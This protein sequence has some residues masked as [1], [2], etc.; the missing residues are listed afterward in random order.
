MYK[1]DPIDQQI[2]NERVAQYRDQTR[3][4]LAGEL[5]DEEFRPLRLQN[6]LYIQR[7]APMLRIAVPYGLM[8]SKQLRKLADIAKRYDRGY[9]HFSTR[10]NLQ[11]NWPKLEDTPEILAEL[12]TV[13]MHAIQTSGNC[14]RNITTDQFA[15]IAPDEIIDPR[16]I[17]EIMRQWSTF[18]PE[19]ALLPR[20]FK[21]AVSGTEKD[22]AIV[23]AHDIGLE[24]YKDEQGQM[25]IKV[26]VGGGLGRTPILG[27][28][29][30][31]HLEWQHVL[32]YCEAVIR[33]YNIH[34]RRDNIYKAR[35]K[36][37][38]K[39]LG[40]DEFRRQVD[41]E[42]AHLKDGP[43]TITQAELDRVAQ[44]F[45]PMPYKTLPAHDASFDAAVASNPA[46]AAWIKRC[47]HAHRVPGYRAVTLSLKPHGKAP[48]DIT[49]DQMHV[50][51]DLA[52]AY[53]FGE[54][55]SSHEQN[56]ILA[57]VQLSD[58]F[59][60]WEKARA[61]GLATPN[62]GLLTDIICCPGGDFCSLANAK[63]IPI[64]EAIQMQF[65]NLDYLYEIGDLE[66][67]ISGCMNACGHHHVGHIG[68]L[69]VDK[70]GSE[71]YQVT[72]GGKQGN[73]AS[74]GTVIGPSFSA[75]EMP[76][77]VK[78][79]IEVY[80][81]ERND[82]ERFIDT[83]RRLGVAPFKAHVYAEKESA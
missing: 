69:G 45:E 41:E 43:L 36:I 51:A 35:I 54:L 47:V 78:R 68:I 1:Y 53:S 56:L 29:I 15:G 12:A 71:W 4:Y 32:S 34:G 37:L 67:N 58:L 66:L 38:V 52:D 8:S 28:V 80:V 81:R 83:V 5:T 33:V 55:R 57:D 16:A 72:I 60:V 19:F 40:I 49:S 30:R 64:A 9:G 22:R 70:D 82:E 48:G 11:L 74:I 73:D 10:Q 13:E 3:R 21:I 79:L 23:Q 61:A 7:H 25:A 26:W 46:F 76:G 65:D 31:E 77:V 27:T 63:S 59:A 39:A 18:H 6:G 44:Y 2:V 20:K 24:F 62:I 14:I 75:E 42:W 50:V 17:A